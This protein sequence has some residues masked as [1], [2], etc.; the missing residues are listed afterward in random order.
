MSCYTQSTLTQRNHGKIHK[1][2]Y[3]EHHKNVTTHNRMSL[4]LHWECPE[5]DSFA[6]RNLPPLLPKVIFCD[7]TYASPW[8]LWVPH[9]A[10]TRQPEVFLKPEMVSD[11]SRSLPSHSAINSHQGFAIVI[12]K[13]KKDRRRGET[14]ICYLQ[15]EQMFPSLFLL[16]LWWFIS[17]CLCVV[18]QW[19]G[20]VRG[21]LPAWWTWESGWAPAQTI[22][23][24]TRRLGGTRS[25]GWSSR[26]FPNDPEFLHKSLLLSVTLKLLTERGESLN[27]KHS[28]SCIPKPSYCNVERKLNSHQ[29][30]DLHHLP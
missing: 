3:I 7:L 29:D 17:V 20:F 23:R 15:A 4:W 2:Q 22:R 26:S 1:T 28:L 10:I 19:K 11:H 8:G 30:G 16:C 24:E 5:I 14:D 6:A 13:Y 25:P 21:S 12:G 27:T 18:L 9:P